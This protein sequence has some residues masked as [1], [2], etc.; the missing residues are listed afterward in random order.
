MIP[1]PCRIS[2]MPPIYDSVEGESTGRS[3]A[4]TRREVMV[5]HGG[6]PDEFNQILEEVIEREI[7]GKESPLS[8]SLLTDL[9]SDRPAKQFRLEMGY[10]RVNRCWHRSCLSSSWYQNRETSVR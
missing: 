10:N 7:S 1:T 3:E 2:S 9:N 4:R 8:I 6:S 5:V